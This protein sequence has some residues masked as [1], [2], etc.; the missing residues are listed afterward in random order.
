MGRFLWRVERQAARG[1]AITSGFLALQWSR[2]RCSDEQT[3][4]D[5]RLRGFLPLRAVW[6]YVLDLEGETEN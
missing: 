5:L 1:A 3:P 2:E 4:F 6:Y